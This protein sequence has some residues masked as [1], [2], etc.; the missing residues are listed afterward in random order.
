MLSSA[1]R[2]F[3]TLILAATVAACD[4]APPPVPEQIRPIRSFVVTE[5]ATGQV[6]R[7]TGVVEASDS[8][9]LS[10]Q[11]SGNVTE[12][13]ANQGA[14]V[15]AGQVLATLDPEPFQL[16]VQAAEADL[17]RA[18]AELAQAK[19]EFD[20]QGTL[21]EQGWVARAR[22]ENAERDYRAAASNVD[23]GVARLNLARRDLN[24]TTLTAPFGGFISQRAVDPFVKVQA[25][26]ALFRIE[27]EDGFDAVFAVPETAISDIV[28]GMP[29]SVQVPRI[30]P[31]LEALVTEIDTSAATG[32]AFAVKATL[33]APPAALRSGMTAQVTLLLPG[34]AGEGGYLVP[35]ST[36][37]PGPQA[38][39]GF[40]FVYDPATSTVRRTAVVSTQSLIGNMV[41]VTGVK[42]GDILASAG[43]NF[44]IDGQTVTLMDGA[45][46]GG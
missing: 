46:A 45:G 2:L 13:L 16:N 9:S 37:A 41:A 22:F 29:A 6:R 7:F 12:V 18:R 39:K 3:M 30:Y 23:L 28:L 44:L 27:A 33:L 40:V 42:A 1:K 15:T 4:E 19:A 5:A 21:Y 14:Q 31:E 38:G 34:A 24:N 35:L 32:S 36:V 20:R 26:Q 43:V 17:Q 8:S 11:I 10:F 25:G